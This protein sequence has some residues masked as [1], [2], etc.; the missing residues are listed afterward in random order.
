MTNTLPQKLKSLRL[1]KGFSQQYV[2]EELSVTR[3]TIYNYETGKRSP[4]LNE[5]QKLAAIYS[6]DLSFFGFAEKEEVFDLVARGRVVFESPDVPIQDKE[7]LYKE[8]MK[9]YL[10][11]QY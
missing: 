2:A 6:V 9:M 1:E 11:L 8:F 7:G 10:N 3:T 5:L 4:H